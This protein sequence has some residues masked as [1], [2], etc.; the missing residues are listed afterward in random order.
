MPWYLTATTREGHWLNNLDNVYDDSDELDNLDNVYDDC[1]DSRSYC[2]TL[3]RILSSFPN[4]VR[5]G[6]HSSLNL[7]KHSE[8]E[9]QD[10]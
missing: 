9:I 8:Y 3:Y 4:L 10:A 6:L 2:F 5:Y 1:D 7:R